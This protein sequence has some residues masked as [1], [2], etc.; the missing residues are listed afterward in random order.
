MVYR[1]LCICDTETVYL[2]KLSA[3][4]NRK[5]GFMWRIKTYTD[6]EACLKEHSEVVLVSG[7][8]LFNW[9]KVK[10]DAELPEIK[11]TRMILLE[12]ECG[13]PMEYPSVQKYQD[14]GQ[15]YEALLEILAEEIRMNTEVIGVYGPANGPNAELF[16]RKLGKE[17][18]KDGDVLIVPLVEFPISVTRDMDENGIGEW[19]YYRS[20]RMTDKLRLSEW[21]ITEEGLDYLQGFRTV[22]DAR[23]ISLDAWH[24][25]FKEGLRK[26]RYRTAIL[27]FDRMP[28][29]IELFMWCDTI[30]AQ[31]GEDD[32][33]FLRRQKFEKMTAY[34]EIQELMEK[35]RENEW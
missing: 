35:I 31:W 11:G 1:Q 33:G 25:F 27:V 18:L 9:S 2:K 5:P 34:M 29:Y 8:A 19:F 21:V 7:T 23:E 13:N 26:S 14:A 32:Y 3:Y 6:F 4:L 20:Q 12:D 15:L 16:A 10:K 22:Y 17:C 28:E 30:Y 24:S